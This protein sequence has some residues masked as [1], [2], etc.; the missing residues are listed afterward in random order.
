M[1]NQYRESTTI[2]GNF[3]RNYQPAGYAPTSE[4]GL[5]PSS[6]PYVLELSEK[7]APNSLLSATIDGIEAA[8]LPWSY[9]P[10]IGKVCIDRDR[11]LAKFNS[12]DA[13][14]LFEL[15]YVPAGS[16]LTVAKFQALL[17]GPQ[18]YQGEQGEAGPQGP[19]GVQGPQGYQGSTGPQG[20]SGPQGFTGSQGPQGNQ[21]SI[22]PQGSTG[23][24]GSQGTQGL[25][26]FQGY[27]GVQGATGVQGPQGTQGLRGFQGFQGATGAQG[28]Q[29]T[30][31]GVLDDLTDVV[32]SGSQ[33]G[34]FLKKSGAQWVDSALSSGD[35]TQLYPLKALLDDITAVRGFFSFEDVNNEVKKRQIAGTGS[36]ITV[37]N[38]DGWL[39]NPTIDVGSNIPK[40]NTWN[41]FSSGVT[42]A[43]LSTTAGE[44]SL[45]DPLSSLYAYIYHYDSELNITNEIGNVAVNVIGS[46]NT[47]APITV[48]YSPTASYVNSLSINSSSSPSSPSNCNKR[49]LRISS[50]GSRIL[51]M[52]ID[53]YSESHISTSQ[54]RLKFSVGET[55]HGQ[56]QLDTSLVNISTN[57]TVAGATTINAA[58][59]TIN[60]G[61]P[62]NAYTNPSI[63]LGYRSSGYG[64]NAFIHTRHHSGQLDN[65]TI[66]FYTSNGQQGGTFSNAIHGLTVM[67]GRIGIGGV[68]TPAVTVDAAGSIRS[69][70]GS[71]STVSSGM[72]VNPG[73][74]AG[75]LYFGTNDA[76]S[77]SNLMRLH[78]SQYGLSFT[79]MNASSNL[80]SYYF[81]S[82]NKH[83]YF[84][85]TSSGTNS[86]AQLQLTGTGNANPVIVMAM[87]VNASGTT[88]NNSN[89]GKLELSTYSLGASLTLYKPSGDTT[90]HVQ[91]YG[92]GVCNMTVDGY[93]EPAE[94][95]A[96]Y[97]P[98]FSRDGSC[99][100]VLIETSPAWA[101]RDGGMVYYVYADGF[102]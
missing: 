73:G 77:L 57:L 65:N 76:G 34:K 95:I 100:M 24:Q 26:G 69:T 82:N 74:E 55:L 12:L 96:P 91:N 1:L 11:G 61:D 9:N 75:Y 102:M 5:I 4:S 2:N 80:H 19:T 51:Y 27:Q 32:L 6:A 97:F 15:G 8:V 25:R 89:N 40:L 78:T 35:F 41:T 22:G 18:G 36:N 17:P 67:N 20:I 72:P 58:P 68:L 13:A 56:M 14:K 23:P 94:L 92:P 81:T 30:A 87:G 66:E 84:N 88:L 86:F 3:I 28:P 60:N 43:Y 71:L 62:S 59:L 38:G 45:V 44:L 29:G 39:G 70:G 53:T 83:L 48:N 42:A 31:V 85:L 7:I 52:G 79:F 101:W 63:V 64:Y 16:N 50:Q 98:A 37:T 54:G 10:G 47:T 49:L 21:G 90:F 46:L 33:S 93:L 99:G